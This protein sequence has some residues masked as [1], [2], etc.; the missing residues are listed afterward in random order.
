MKAFRK[1]VLLTVVLCLYGFFSCLK[2]SFAGDSKDSEKKEWMHTIT[3]TDG[4]VE[5]GNGRTV[6]EAKVGDY[7]YIIP[8]LQGGSYV[9]E[10]LIN[11][12]SIWGQSFDM[13]DYD[14]KIDAVRKT[15]TP[16]VL[17]LTK[18]ARIDSSAGDIGHSVGEF[19]CNYFGVDDY[20]DSHISNGRSDYGTDV[21]GDGTKDLFL[22]S[23]AFR[24]NNDY[25]FFRKEGGSARGDIEISAFNNL[26]YWPITLRFGNET[27]AATYSVN[28][29]GGYATKRYTEVIVKS[30]YPGDL[31]GL[32]YNWNNEYALIG[33]EADGIPDFNNYFMSHSDTLHEDKGFPMPSMNLTV[34][35][36]TAKKKPY[37]VNFVNGIAEIPY[38]V[39]VCIGESLKDDNEKYYYFSETFDI[40]GDGTADFKYSNG[41]L[42]VLSSTCSLTG[43]IKLEGTNGGPYWPI[44]L[45][46]GDHQNEYSISVA[47]GHAE[48]QNGNVITK[49]SSGTIIKIVRDKEEG[50]YFN[51]WTSNC[52][53]TSEY[54]NF[55]CFM[56]AQDVIFTAETTTSQREFTVDLT[57][58]DFWPNEE[59][60]VLIKNILQAFENEH[61]K[62]AFAQVDYY[63]LALDGNG[64]VAFWGSIPDENDNI[65]YYLTR[66]GRYQYSL[67]TDYALHVN[68][69]QI[70]T[71]NIIVDNEK[72]LYPVIDKSN[73]TYRITVSNGKAYLYNDEDLY[74]TFVDP[75][76]EAYPGT[77]VFVASRDYPNQ[78]FIGWKIEGISTLY[79]FRTG[80]DHLYYEFVMPPHDVVITTLYNGEIPDEPEPTLTP[81]PTPRPTATPTVRPT[82]TPTATPVPTL[83]VTPEEDNMK[84]QPTSVPKASEPGEDSVHPF[85]LLIA[86][87]V[88]CMIGVAVYAVFY[89]RKTKGTKED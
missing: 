81:T 56:P 70:G 73:G 80:N 34:R 3:I 26:P 23:T 62:K 78:R 32:H 82:A 61:G 4:H 79:V 10:W 24:N 69:G 35:P 7:L 28:V 16:L 89:I 87:L 39:A 38:E 9:S 57:E 58:T 71:L 19:I 66:R 18:C 17:D 68:D 86:G 1:V 85:T 63:D 75:I 51:Y 50:R 65:R 83:T 64:D 60:D 12:E 27:P 49:S 46:V 21:D 48:D 31:V 29:I 40:D 88:L 15:Q 14:I 67:G 6:T 20:W 77:R 44:T 36:V 47:G 53:V 37:V 74:N 72:T 41:K 2:A 55:D 45:Q 42:F 33:W 43:V 84:P 11:G 54:M 59:E 76:S 13:P 22:Y 25:Y 5:D 8:D 30:T 52:G